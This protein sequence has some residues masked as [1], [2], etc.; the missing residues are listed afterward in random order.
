LA[1]DPGNSGE[2]EYF[3]AGDVRDVSWHGDLGQKRSGVSGVRWNG[4]G[5]SNGGGNEVQPSMPT[6]RRYGAVE[7]RLSDMPRGRRNLASGLGGGANTCRSKF[8]I[9]VARRRKGERRC[10]GRTAWRPIDND[11]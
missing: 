11:S 3:A 9:A 5:D 8:G 1:I 6:L 10:S 7:E 4:H 2:A